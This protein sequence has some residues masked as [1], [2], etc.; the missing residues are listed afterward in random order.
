[1]KLAQGDS[2]AETTNSFQEKD[3]DICSR[4]TR[5][6]IAQGG[7]AEDNAKGTRDGTQLRGEIDAFRGDLRQR[8]D[9]NIVDT[10]L[11][12]DDIEAILFASRA[13][14]E[15]FPNP[16]ELP[17]IEGAGPPG[18]LVRRE[19]LEYLASACRLGRRGG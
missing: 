16:A 15:E 10:S 9:E 2:T 11:T 8:I 18:R 5:L 17:S 14:I 19:D 4:L 13:L 3:I 6:F 7:A 12:R 1:L